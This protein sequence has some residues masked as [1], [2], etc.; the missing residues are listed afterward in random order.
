M[1]FYVMIPQPPRSTRPDTLF[2]YTTLFRSSGEQQRHLPGFAAQY[3]ALRAARQLVN[4]GRR[5]VLPEGAAHDAALALL[6]EVV[7]AHEKPVDEKSC[8]NRID[9]H[10]QPSGHAEGAPS[11]SNHNAREAAAHPDSRDG[12]PP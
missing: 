2:P 9:E 12:H 5:Q 4:Q 6:M 10:Q 8:A 11:T 3:Q 7:V 1:C